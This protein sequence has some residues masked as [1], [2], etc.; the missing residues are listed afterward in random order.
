VTAKDIVLLLDAA[1]RGRE[2]VQTVIETIGA[3]AAAAVLVHELVYRAC[4]DEL[5]RS[6]ED[7]DVQFAFRHAGGE[8]RQRVSLRAEG[9]THGPHDG[10]A[11]VALITQDLDEVVRAVLGPRDAVPSNTRTVTWPALWRGLTSLLPSRAPSP[12]VFGL[13][14]RL[15]AV[16]DGRDTAGLTELAVR[17]GADKWGLHQYTGHYDRHF[18]ALRNRRLTVVEI[19][20]GGY[21]DPASGGASLRMWKHYFP[22]ALVYGVDVFDKHPIDQQRIITLQADQGDADSLARFAADIGP[23]DIV[24]DDGSH[25]S[26]HVI[27]SFT[28]LFPYLSPDGLYVVEDMQASYWPPPAYDGNPNDL[29]DPRSS[30]G[31]F[32][33]LLD[34]LHHEEFLEPVR[35]PVST[36]QQITGV[37]FYH[38]IVV[39]E[40][41]PN[42]DGSPIARLMR[43]SIAGSQVGDR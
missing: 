29:G 4:L 38:N 24:I 35:E 31:F 43:E 21:Q 36:D 9:V 40:K 22:R 1:A 17:Y 2:E 34:G 3:D 19:G 27:T 33:T 16:L 8:A 7:L 5:G 26:R 42:R 23:I 15:L 6:D 32:K 13:V 20:I 41:G 18:A 11:P 39:V 30:M 12:V 10:Q 37:H 28:T 25:L 14:R